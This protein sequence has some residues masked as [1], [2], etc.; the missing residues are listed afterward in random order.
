ML[1]NVIERLGRNTIN[2][3]RFAFDKSPSFPLMIC[4]MSNQWLRLGFKH[5]ECVID[6]FVLHESSSADFEGKSQHW[7]TH[8]PSSD[9]QLCKSAL[10]GAKIK[11]LVWRSPT[12]LVLFHKSAVDVN[13]QRFPRPLSTASLPESV[14]IDLDTN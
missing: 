13:S 4:A 2:I 11:Q 6:L 3:N 10:D 1:I 9:L 5:S 7:R 14:P 8:R 12:T